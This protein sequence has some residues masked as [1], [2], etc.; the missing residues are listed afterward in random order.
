MNYTKAKAIVE[1]LIFASPDPISPKRI[2]ELTGLAPSTAESLV[3]DIQEKYKRD[4]SG[5]QVVF[6]AGGYEMTTRPEVAEYVAKLNVG[7]RQGL[8]RPALETLAIIAY[9]QPITR[10][11]L[12]SIRGV[13]VDSVLNTLLE[14]RLIRVSGRKKAPGRP[15]LYSTTPVFL[16][17]FGLSSMD[18]LP[19]LTDLS[20]SSP[21][22]IL[23]SN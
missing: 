9:K 5:I 18:D 17:W 16:Q 10:P 4:K 15:A 23:G 12:E 14:R 19:P 11:E 1:A 20:S 21:P 3:K 7:V 13:R 8:S 2:A 6:V 22:N